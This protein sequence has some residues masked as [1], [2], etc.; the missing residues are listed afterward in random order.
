MGFTQALLMSGARSVCLSLWEVDDT[1]TAL[2]MQ[3][4]YAN[5]LGARPGLSQP[6][7]KVADLA[8]AKEWLRNPQDRER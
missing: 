2:L 7:S 5:M 3:Q 1:A 4:F 8:E 6:M